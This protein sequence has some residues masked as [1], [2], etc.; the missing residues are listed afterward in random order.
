MAKGYVEINGRIVQG[1]PMVYAVPTDFN[2][3]KP[4]VKTDGTLATAE[5][6][7]AVATPKGREQHWNQ[8]EWGSRIWN[9][10]QISWPQGEWQMK[11]F[12]WKVVDGDS[13]ELNKNMK[14]PCDHEGFPG[15]W[16]IS[17]KAFVG[18]PT[19]CF[20]NGKYGQGDI[21][22]DPGAIKTGDYCRALFTLKTNGQAP[23]KTPG[24]YL[25]CF[26]FDMTRAGEEI[27]SGPDAGAMFGQTAPVIPPNAKL[28]PAVG[29]PPPATGGYVTPGP[30]VV[31]QP[32]YPPPAPAVMP[33]APAI[34]PPAAPNMGFVQG[35]PAPPPAPV[36]YRLHSDG[37]SYT[38][39]QLKGW[40]WTPDQINSLPI[41][42]GV[43]VPF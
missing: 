33:P 21:L 10:G 4:K 6:F 40:G 25:T 34:V 17:L 1:H 35:P 9:E 37:K 32:Q 8:T 24:L 26:G 19:Q 29:A 7:F 16:I 31:Q 42:T 27:I 14:R 28:D 30:P 12:A 15:H 36:I 13:T 43:D 20:A 2:T 11:D 22:R 3:K 39:D 23:P 41:S 18:N 5:S 38:E